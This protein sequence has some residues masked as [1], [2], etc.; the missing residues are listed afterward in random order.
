MDGL[1]ELPGAPGAAA[2]LAEDVPGLE[3]MPLSRTFPG[4][5]VT[6]TRNFAVVRQ[7]GWLGL[8]PR[9][10]RGGTLGVGCPSEPGFC[11]AFKAVI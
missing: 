3:P 2:E 6:R 9:G 10:G 7:A 8:L 1:G 11:L 4:E 5:G